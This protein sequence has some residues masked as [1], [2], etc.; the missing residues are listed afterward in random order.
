MCGCAK[1]GR[2]FTNQR[3]Q[4]TMEAMPINAIIHHPCPYDLT[5]SVLM[6][7]E[8]W[9]IGKT[10]EKYLEEGIALFEKRLR[11]YLP[12]QISILPGIKNAGNLSAAQL[13]Q[14]EGE[15]IL[16]KLKKEDYFILLDERGKTLSSEE[17]AHHLEPKL[18]LSH[19][20][21][22]SKSE[23]PTAFPKPFWRGPTNVYPCP[24]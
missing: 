14:K 7:M 19:K 3:S 1:Y 15:L 9:F 8:L 6:K 4:V 13:M 2:R 16:N 22:I 23:E 24:K 5:T 12:I 10:T 17:F 21:L 11:H 18:Q 20:R